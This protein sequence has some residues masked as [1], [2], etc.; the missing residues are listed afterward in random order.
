MLNKLLFYLVV[1][2][3]S[4]LP[5]WVLHIIS[6]LAKFLIYRVFKYR[7]GV[8]MTS[9]RNSFP[10]KSESELK[11]IASEFYRHFTDIVIES[12]KMFSISEKSLAK[13]MV[14][15]NSE[16][17][18]SYYKE[19][20]D[21]VLVSGHYGSWEMWATYGAQHFPHNPRGV[22]KPLKNKFWDD[23][24]K[25][26][27]GK[28]GMNLVP[29]KEAAK[30]FEI[31]DEPAAVIL[32]VDQSPARSKKCYW[33]TFLSQDTAVNFGMESIA[34]KHNAAVI[35]GDIQ[36]VKRSHYEVTWSVISDDPSSEPYGMITEK[37][38]AKVEEKVRCNPQYWLWTHKRWKRKRRDDEELFNVLKGK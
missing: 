24:A 29:V 14:S 2:P 1:K 28:Y 25:K 37:A 8:V 31:I 17:F 13:R 32:L 7:V 16:I 9:L 5:F 33:T 35:Y 15:M 4:L 6:D 36:K 22:Y 26:S 21:L 11:A 18:D 23:Q 12:V 20:K 34:K 30:Q 3:I 10:E 27:R 38:T 19:G